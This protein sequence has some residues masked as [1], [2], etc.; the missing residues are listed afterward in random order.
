MPSDVD[1]EVMANTP[2][3][4]DY[5]VL[6]LSASSIARSVAP[7]QFVMLKTG[8]NYDPLLRRPFSI[9]EVLRD[10][11]GQETGFSILNK[12]IGAST[13]LLYEAR[14]GQRAACLGPL[15]RPFTPVDPPSEA[16]MVAGGVG[17]APF[18]ELA[19]ALRA[20]SV[21]TTLFYG[22]RSAS[23]L[24]HLDLFRSL[25]VTLVVTT[26]DGTA[27]ERGRIVTPLERAF[28]ERPAGVA[29]MT[30]ACGPEGMLAAT[31]QTARRF[32]RPCEVSVER[33]MGCGLGGCYSCV[34][35]MRGSR[36]G[37]HHVR[38]CLAGPVLP[39]DQILWD[40]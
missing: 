24:F 7:G 26:E 11:S 36:G 20:R 33:I 22:A 32:A 12:R 9:F 13:R 29:V 6:A 15:G 5:N 4:T 8:G 27:G 30:Y 1:A 40:G 2:L 3:T 16:W 21:S 14:R 31:A 25:G 34:V 23:E 37:F 17:L 10:R 35:L 28:A 39:A 19:R 38:S 18:A